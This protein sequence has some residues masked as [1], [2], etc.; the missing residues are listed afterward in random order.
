MPIQRQSDGNLAK[1]Q[2]VEQLYGGYLVRLGTARVE[3]KQTTSSDLNHKFFYDAR[4]MYNTKC[5]DQLK[6]SQ[7][8]KKPVSLPKQRLHKDQLFRLNF[9]QPPII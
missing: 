6:V 2:R 9:D 1:S 7:R 8:S 4:S 5:S 3:D